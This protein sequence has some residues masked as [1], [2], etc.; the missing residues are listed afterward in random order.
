MKI[1]KGQ[2]C[3]VKNELSFTNYENIKLY[4]KHE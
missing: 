1:A 3:I 4:S 2:N